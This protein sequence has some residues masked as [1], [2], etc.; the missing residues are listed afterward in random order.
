[1]TGSW[2]RE[3]GEEMIPVRT[4]DLVTVVARLDQAQREGL[5]PTD[6]GGPAER[7]LTCDLPRL[8]AYLPDE[9]VEE[10]RS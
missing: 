5:I 10:M 7:L 1:M 3:H 4:V 8:M 9:A 6:G 2:I